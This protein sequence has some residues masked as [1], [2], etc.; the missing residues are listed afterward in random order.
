MYDEV[1]NGFA[2]GGKA[3]ALPETATFP[4]LRRAEKTRHLITDRAGYNQPGNCIYVGA[5]SR[6]S[7]PRLGAGAGE[8]RTPP[9]ALSPRVSAVWLH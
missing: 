6:Q 8:R 3:K 4:Q 5:W 9:R 1:I 7:L 2:G